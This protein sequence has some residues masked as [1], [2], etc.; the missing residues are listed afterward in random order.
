MLEYANAPGAP[1][2][3][4]ERAARIAVPGVSGW[5]DGPAVPVTAGSEE[6]SASV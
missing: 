5:A 3:E 6:G 4:W 1:A 2:G